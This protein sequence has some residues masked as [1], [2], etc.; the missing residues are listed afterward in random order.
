[1][2]VAN[3]Q[4]ACVQRGVPRTASQGFMP[5]A[6]AR[7]ALFA[8][9]LT[10]P[11]TESLRSSTNTHPHAPTRHRLCACACAQPLCLC[12]CLGLTYD[13]PW[14]CGVQLQTCTAQQGNTWC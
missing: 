14:L 9:S 6:R 11:L 13:V 1:M 8:S 2:R 12:L 3:V 5:V 4:V 7:V 10:L